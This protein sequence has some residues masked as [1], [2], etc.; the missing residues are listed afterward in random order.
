MWT[1]QISDRRLV[2]KSSS[3]RISARAACRFWLTITK[4]D[5]KM[6]SRLTIIVSSPK[7]NLSNLA[8]AP[9][10]PTFTSTQI[11]NHTECR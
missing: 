10:T 4:V 8:D 9:R 1:D 6:A 2:S 5:R 11:P 3:L 7:G